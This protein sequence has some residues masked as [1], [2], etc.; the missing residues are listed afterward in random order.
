MSSSISIIALLSFSPSFSSSSSSPF[1]KSS[2]FV[3]HKCAFIAH[4]APDTNTTPSNPNSSRT[5]LSISCLDVLKFIG[6]SVMISQHFFT[7]SSVTFNTSCMQCAQ[8]SFC[9]CELVKYP[10]SI[11]RRTMRPLMSG[12]SFES[13]PTIVAFVPCGRHAQFGTKA[14]GESW[15]ANPILIVSPPLSITMMFLWIGGILL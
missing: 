13:K 5:I 10:L 1:S 2:S 7:S 8:I 15:P 11:G 4:N 12:M 14:V 3:C 9:N 6:G